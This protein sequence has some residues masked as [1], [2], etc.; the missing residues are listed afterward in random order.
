MAKPTPGMIASATSRAEGLIPPLAI[1]AALSYKVTMGEFCLQFRSL[2]SAQRMRHEEQK[3]IAEMKAGRNSKAPVEQTVLTNWDDILECRINGWSYASIADA[4]RGKQE[5]VG[6]KDNTGFV[7]A[8]KRVARRKGVDLAQLNASGLSLQSVSG[9]R[10]SL[11][12]SDSDAHQATMEGAQQP[13]ASKTVS[14][15]FQD[16]RHSSD[17]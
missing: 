11:A 6:N 2:P 5:S 16:S 9:E 1:L 14:P 17:F 12:A 3:T 13:S 15:S 7:Q 4:Y 10:D 8:V